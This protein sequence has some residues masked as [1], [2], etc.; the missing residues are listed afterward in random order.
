MKNYLKTVEFL[1][2]IYNIYH[3][4]SVQFFKDK[5]TEVIVDQHLET[6][7]RIAVKIQ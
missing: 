2:Y 4:N 1:I 6:Q 3:F 5:I 7:N